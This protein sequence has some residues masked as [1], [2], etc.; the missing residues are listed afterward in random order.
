MLVLV[1]AQVMGM[2]F[3]SGVMLMRMSVPPVYRTVL[4][5]VRVRVR[6]QGVTPCLF[7]T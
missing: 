5:Q 4:S 6:A 1:F 2:Y 7:T 3:V